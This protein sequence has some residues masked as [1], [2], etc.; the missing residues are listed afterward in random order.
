MVE[1]TTISVHPDRAAA[2]RDYRD[3]RE[4][5]NMDAALRELLEGSA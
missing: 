3:E 5:P 2:I 1:I 4:L